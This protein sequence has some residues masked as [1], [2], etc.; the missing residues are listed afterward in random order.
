MKVDCPNDTL[1]AEAP[2]PA[3]KAARIFSLSFLI[4]HNVDSG[5]LTA[6]V[7]ALVD[8]PLSYLLII[9]TF[10]SIVHVFLLIFL[11]RGA[12]FLLKSHLGA[13]M[14]KGH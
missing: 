13:V 1:V 4:V 12:S 2:A 5:M 14:H 3:S 10:C 7:M 9:S 6:S 8:S 11:A